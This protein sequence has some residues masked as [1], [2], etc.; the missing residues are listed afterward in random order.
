VGG[1][2]LSPRELDLGYVLSDVDDSIGPRRK[3]MY[4]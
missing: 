4:R 3:H 2:Q 1:V